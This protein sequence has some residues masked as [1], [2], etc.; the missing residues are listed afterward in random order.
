VRLIFGFLVLVFLVGDGLIFL[1][2][3]RAA[4]LAGFLCILGILLPVLLVVF[5]LWIADRVVRHQR[6]LD[7]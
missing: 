5:I 4:G 3:G 1:Y 2:Y 7:D 6:Q